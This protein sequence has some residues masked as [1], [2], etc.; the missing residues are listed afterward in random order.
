MKLTN[1]LCIAEAFPAII[2]CPSD[3]IS[4]TKGS[5]NVPITEPMIKN[6]RA[7]IIRV[8]PEPNVN[9]TPEPHPFA[10]CIPKPKMKAPISKDKFTGA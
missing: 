7:T 9:R 2:I 4:I 6:G 5:M 8:A 1:V 3:I 10:S